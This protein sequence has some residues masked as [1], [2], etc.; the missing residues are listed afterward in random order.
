VL[1]TILGAT[2]DLTGAAGLAANMSFSV[3]RDGTI[4][5]I[6]AY[7]SIVLALSLAGT[8]LTVTAQLYESTTPNNIFSPVA[9]TAIALTPPFSGII[10]VG[11]I[12]TGSLTG[13]SIPVVTGTRLLM[14]F[15]VTAEGLSLINTVTGYASAGVSIS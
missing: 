8:D 2:I 5:D 1:P 3:P 9:G 11:D 15:S 6:T 4:T 13:L 14:V 7:F 10:S 12:A